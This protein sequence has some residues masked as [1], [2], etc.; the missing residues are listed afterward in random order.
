MTSRGLKDR[1]ATHKILNPKKS[2]EKYIK[3]IFVMVGTRNN[4]SED[5]N[6][7]NSDLNVKK[8]TPVYREAMRRPKELNSHL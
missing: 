3:N 4:L 7:I 5:K 8:R 2:N 1:S 6:V